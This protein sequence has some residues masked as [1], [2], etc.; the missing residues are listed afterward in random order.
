MKSAIK[1]FVSYTISLALFTTQLYAAANC[2]LIEQGCKLF[3]YDTAGKKKLCVEKKEVWLCS[4]SHSEQVGCSKYERKQKCG[5]FIHIP[6][7]MYETKDFSSAFMDAMAKVASF[8]QLND[9]WAGWHGACEYGWFTDF[10]WLTDPFFLLSAATTMA[11]AGIL[12][13]QVKDAYVGAKNALKGWLS[14]GLFGDSEFA[15][16]MAA[17]GL[18]PTNILQYSINGKKTDDGG[19]LSQDKPRMY[20]S[21]EEWGNFK[22]IADMNGFKYT[23]YASPDGLG[24]HYVQFESK[25]DAITTKSMQCDGTL[26]MAGN[27]IDM[28]TGLMSGSV[29]GYLKAA[30]SAMNLATKTDMIGEIGKALNISAPMMGFL[31]QVAINI[32]MSFNK[33]NACYDKECAMQVDS[34]GLQVKT[35]QFMNNGMC[36][37]INTHCSWKTL[38]GCLRHKSEYCCYDQKLTRIFVEQAKLQLNKGWDSCNDLTFD[39]LNRLSFRQCQP[40]E[41]QNVS[42]C[43]DFTEFIAEIK[44]QISADIDKDSISQ[45]AAAALGSSVVAP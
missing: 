36:H 11:E 14:G 8:D 2:K 21:L 18:S 16:C 30:N 25:A 42:K 40:G 19:L 34:S 31:L 45:A 1:T 6:K 20:I 15:A 13:E 43:M 10:S 33:C 35:N 9:V 17:A 39:D 38:F 32:I 29:S 26:G 5:G 23:E 12:G 44:K 7:D 22:Q 24:G 27:G 4:T 41:E 28:A 3:K 37:Y